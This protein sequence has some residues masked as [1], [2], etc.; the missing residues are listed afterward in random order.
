MASA[1]ASV[2]S[3]GLGP[4]MAAWTLLYQTYTAIFKTMER[5][6]LPLGISPP[7]AF[8]LAAIRFSEEPMTPGRLAGLLAQETQSLTGLVDRMEAQGWVARMRDLPDR[9][10]IRLA[11]TPAGEAKLDEVMPYNAKAADEV[12][13]GL[14]PDRL[15]ELSRILEEMRPAVL[16][17]I[18][19]D[20]ERSRGWPPVAGG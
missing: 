15:A 8:A 12:F 17:Q 3:R 20:P 5:A 10:T 2:S 19:L 13:V 7:Q 4:Q 11:L 16:G 6:L 14:T 1:S 9:R 18:G